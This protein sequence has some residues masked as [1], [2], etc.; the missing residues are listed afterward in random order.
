MNYYYGT[1][2]TI[3]GEI[4]IRVKPE[5]IQGDEVI[6]LEMPLS[7]QVGFTGGRTFGK[8][9]MKKN[10]HPSYLVDQNQLPVV[11]GFKGASLKCYPLFGPLF[12]KFNPSFVARI[13]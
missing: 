4:T 8:P 6:E 11:Y 5:N 7:H 13:P 9:I 12:R 3:G 1:A 10:G 2:I